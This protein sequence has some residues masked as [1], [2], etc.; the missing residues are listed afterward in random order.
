MLPAWL[1]D[2]AVTYLAHIRDGVALRELARV[3]GVHP[4]TVMRQVRRV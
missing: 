2:H 1:P 3:K 4:S